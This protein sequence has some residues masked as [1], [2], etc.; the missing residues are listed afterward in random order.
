MN[1]IKNLMNG[2]I[3]QNNLF[4]KSKFIYSFNLIILN[5]NGSISDFISQLIG[6]K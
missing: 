3:R 6:R 1:N 5:I 4:T 2:I